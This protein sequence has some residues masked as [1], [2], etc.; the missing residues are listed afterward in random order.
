LIVAADYPF[1]DIFFTIVVF[2]AW[3]AWFSVLIS[4]LG[5]IFGRDDMSGWGKAGWVLFVVVVPFLGVLVYLGTQG[6]QMAARKM[7]RAQAQRAQM[8]DYVREVAGTSA[9]G[10]SAAEIAQAKA[11]LDS[12][13]IDQ[14][15]F[16][17]LKQKA[18]G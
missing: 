18:L 5:D 11:L 2:F 8:D 17:R 10:G 7:A 4:V 1:L 12:G 3:V 9:G 6:Q 13:A 15:E 14:A 16:E